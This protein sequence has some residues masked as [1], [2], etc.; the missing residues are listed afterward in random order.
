[1]RFGGNFS[2]LGSAAEKGSLSTFE[3]NLRE[4]PT[5]QELPQPPLEG[6][7][8]FQDSV[9]TV[10]PRGENMAAAQERERPGEKERSRTL[11]RKGGQRRPNTE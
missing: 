8:F 11:K 10:V 7:S 2:L 4:M 9:D 5:S 6:V 1:M 3:Q